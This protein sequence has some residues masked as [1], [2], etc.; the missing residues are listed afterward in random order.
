MSFPSSSTGKTSDDEFDN[1]EAHL[2]VRAQK[3]GNSDFF[4]DYGEREP[5]LCDSVT[6]QPYDR[7]GRSHTTSS[8]RLPPTASYRPN[9]KGATN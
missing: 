5:L 4:K 8:V 9:P 6:E 3:F 7:G 2:K 1:S